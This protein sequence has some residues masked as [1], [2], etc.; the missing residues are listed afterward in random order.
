MIKNAQDKLEKEKAALAAEQETVPYSKILMTF[1][2]GTDKILMSFGYFFAV[3]TGLG[4]PSFTFLFGDIVVNFTDPSTSIVDA[5]NP[6]CM[7]L[8]IIGGVMFASSYFYFVF[9]VI[10]AER[11]TKKTRVAYLRSILK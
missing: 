11:I 9:L 2:D 5:I 1:A 10:M 3:V 7:Q 4:V 8:L 6:L